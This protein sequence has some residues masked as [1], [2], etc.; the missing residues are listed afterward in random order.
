VEYITE[1]NIL[2]KVSPVYETHPYGNIKQ[3]DF[4]NAVI[5]VSTNMDLNSFFDHIKEAERKTGRTPSEKWGEREIDIDILLFGNEI[6]SNDI[7]TIPHKGMAERDFVLQPLSDIAP[8]L[9]HPVLKKT[10]RELLKEVTEKN[11]IR[12]FPGKIN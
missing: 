6:I 9:L 10:I 3:A 1:E 7:I 5:A 2:L 4:L 8:D 11:I 12:I